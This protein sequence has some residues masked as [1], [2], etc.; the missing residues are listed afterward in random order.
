MRNSKYKWG[1]LLAVKKMSGVINFGF[2]S[3]LLNYNLFKSSFLAVR[4]VLDF[5]KPLML[6]LS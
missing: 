5:Q 2:Q 3:I 4:D 1:R 6:F